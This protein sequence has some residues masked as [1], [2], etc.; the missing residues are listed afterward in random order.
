VC[1]PCFSKGE[2]EGEVWEVSVS[3]FGGKVLSFSSSLTTSN[4]YSTIL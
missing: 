1:L 4:Y 3:G 2:E